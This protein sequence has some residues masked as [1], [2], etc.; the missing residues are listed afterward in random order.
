MAAYLVVEIDVKDQAEFENYKKMS[1]AAVLAHGGKF[2]VRGG[3]ITTLEGDWHPKRFVIVEFE[4]VEKARQFWNSQEYEQA[5]NLRQ[6]IAT[7]QMILVEG[8]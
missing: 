1:G 5:K 7:T 2:L 4:S 6:R 8:T 3:A